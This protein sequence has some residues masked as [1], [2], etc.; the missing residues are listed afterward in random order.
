LRGQ[1]DG[2]T[3]FLVELLHCDRLAYLNLSENMLGDT[4]VRGLASSMEAM[5]WLTRLDLSETAMSDT[6]LRALAEAMPRCPGLL[7]LNLALNDYT[8]ETRKEMQDAW[9]DAQKRPEYLVW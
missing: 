8:P 1:Q 3:P 6:G 7:K 9:R 5:P 4:F 2:G